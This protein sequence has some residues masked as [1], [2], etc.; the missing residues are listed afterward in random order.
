MPSDHYKGFSLLDA[1]NRARGERAEE[2]VQWYFRL[3]GFMLIPG[4]IVHPDIQ[5]AKPRTEADII[6]VRLKYSSESFWVKKPRQTFRES[7]SLRPVPMRDD[8][9]LID[10]GKTGSSSKHLVA[11]VEV[12]AGQ[13]NINGPWSD[14]NGLSGHNSTSNM[15]RAISRIGFCENR[16]I[17]QTVAQAMYRDLR[18]EGDE[19]VIQYFSVGKFKNPDLQAKYPKLVQITFDQIG[20]F[21]KERFT[22]FPQKLPLNTE[23]TLWKGFGDEFRSWFETHGTNQDAPALTDCQKAIACFIEHGRCTTC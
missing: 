2:V 13:C 23:I 5:S 20:A 21:L 6:G 22:R 10:S 17:V 1:E 19:F 7:E 16:S 18:H 15:E 14:Q 12:K 9:L 11:L 3:N 8:V 4:F